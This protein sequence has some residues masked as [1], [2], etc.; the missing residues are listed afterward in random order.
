MEIFSLPF[1]LIQLT[2]P[3]F[4]LSISL[5]P[6]AGPNVLIQ[7]IGDP[8]EFNENFMFIACQTDIQT[9]ERKLL[10]HLFEKR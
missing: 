8:I 4:N 5:E 7:G 10:P 1:N 2:I 9:M 3:Q 6:Y